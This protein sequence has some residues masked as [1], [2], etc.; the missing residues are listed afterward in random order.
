MSRTTYTCSTCKKNHKINTICKE[1]IRDIDWVV[2][3]ILNWAKKSHIAKE[4]L[5]R[6]KE[7]RNIK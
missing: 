6:A 7:L 2:A 1:E 3:P 4:V 5:R